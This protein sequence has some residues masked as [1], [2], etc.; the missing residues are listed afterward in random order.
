MGGKLSSV[1]V[2]SLSAEQQKQLEQCD[3][4]TQEVVNVFTKYFPKAIN[5]AVLRKVKGE[6]TVN[7]SGA[8]E[9]PPTIIY[10]G[11]CEKK[12]LLNSQYKSRTLVALNKVDNYCLEYYEKDIRKG[13]LLISGS[14]T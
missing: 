14:L 5:S 2:T 7:S 9:I 3:A 1:S 6:S 12:G 8:N 4:L 10:H 13:Y 11:T